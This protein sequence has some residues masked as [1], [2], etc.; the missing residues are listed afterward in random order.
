MSPTRDSYDT[1]TRKHGP[2]REPPHHRAHTGHGLLLPHR[3]PERRE[4]TPAPQF[5]DA[6]VSAFLVRDFRLTQAPRRQQPR[7]SPMQNLLKSILSRLLIHPLAL[8]AI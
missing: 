1:T 3:S 5:Q 4:R 8:V 6:A 7:T 2:T